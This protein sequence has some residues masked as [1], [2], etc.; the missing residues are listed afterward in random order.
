VPAGR[1]PGEREP[2]LDLGHDAR[3][4]PALVP[5]DPAHVVGEAVDFLELDPPR[6]H[7][8]DDDAPAAGPEI[9]G[10]VGTLVHG[11]F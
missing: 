4:V 10:C 5:A 7:A 8:P 3:E 9:D 1:A 6:R 11:R 2:A